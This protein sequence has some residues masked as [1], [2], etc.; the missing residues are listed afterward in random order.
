MQPK[1]ILMK[2]YTKKYYLVGLDFILSSILHLQYYITNQIITST[3][4]KS[5]PSSKFIFLTPKLISLGSYSMSHRLFSKIS[6][7]KTAVTNSCCLHG[8]VYPL[9]SS[10]LSST[11]IVP[12]HFFWVLS[13]VNRYLLFDLRILCFI[14]LWL[15]LVLRDF[16]D[17]ILWL[18]SSCYGL[19]QYELYSITW[20]LLR[21]YSLHKSS[22]KYPG[23]YWS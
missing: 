2:Q 4:K 17:E 1:P 5:S 7:S 12:L 20:L 13:A 8:Q 9:R 6:L 23:I 14:F 10:G 21:Y 22:I 3:I 16:S 15:V 11:F 18:F 19:L